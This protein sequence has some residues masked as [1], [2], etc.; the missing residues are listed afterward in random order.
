MIKNIILDFGGVIIDVSYKA[1]ANA[2]KKLGVKNFDI[3]Y[4]Q[5]KQEH[6]FDD[7]EKGIISDEEFRLQIK[8]HLPSSVSDKQIDAAW[9]SLVLTIP[10]GRINF[11][12]ELKKNYRLILLSNSN[13]IHHRK[14][15]KTIEKDFEKNILNELFEKIYFSCFINM[16]KPDVKIYNHVMKENNL[17]INETIF[18]DDS[19]QHVEGARKAGLTAYHLE[20][21]KTSIEK[22]IPEILSA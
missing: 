9:N 11:L 12:R 20:L 16:R 13:R 8:K 2:F 17:K 6:F 21:T 4:S 14:L 19:I 7:F 1:A 22:F 3:L 10:Q 15:T 5:K 18:I